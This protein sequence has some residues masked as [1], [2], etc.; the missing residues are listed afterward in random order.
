MTR[1]RRHQRDWEDLA[2]LDPLWAIQTSDANR[3]GTDD[4]DSFMA[5]GRRK[6]ETTMLELGRL[7]LPEQH[8]SALDFGC[9]VGRLTLPF[10]DHF[11]TVT[12]VDIAPAMTEQARVRAAGRADVRFLL[13]DRDDLSLLSGEQFDL[14]YTGLVLQHQ[15][16]ARVALRY[17][18]DLA[19]LV[20]AGGVL[21]AQM[22]IAVP[23][24]LRLQHGRRVYATLRRL[25][26]PRDVLYRRLR[27]Q[28]MRMIAVPREAVDR[29]MAD[30]RL[31][32][33]HADQ[34]ERDGVRSVT[35]YAAR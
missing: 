32:I 24:R 27:L 29:C 4:D 13:N 20:G 34:S 28:P 22:P 11:E 1:F 31:R 25:G 12:G 33:L 16:S 17:L 3:L 26:V 19:A 14:V 8:A 10:A 6:V 15:P 23:A 18:G 21:V 2:Q 9:G 5:S 35:V 30:H 7:G